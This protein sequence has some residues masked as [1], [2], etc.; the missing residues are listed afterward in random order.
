MVAEFKSPPLCPSRRK[1]TCL[2]IRISN[3]HNPKIKRMKT[4]L[5]VPQNRWK[6]F[7]GLLIS[8]S[9]LV[10][11]GTPEYNPRPVFVKGIQNAGN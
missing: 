3:P 10:S 11:C 5:K 4:M 6:L 9:V 8:M 2:K 1:I 7:L